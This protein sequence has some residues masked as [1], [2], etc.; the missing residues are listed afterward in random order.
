[1]KEAAF[2]RLSAQTELV[3]V[4]TAF[5]EKA[6]LAS[7]STE[8]EALS[9]TLAG[10][11]IFS[12]LSKAVSGQVLEILYSKASYYSQVT[13]RFTSQRIDWKAF[14]LTARVS[15]DE[16]ASLEDLG[17]LIA[18]RSV[19]RLSIR[20]EKTGGV[21]LTLIKEKSYPAPAAGSPVRGR[22]LA[23]F[24]VRVPYGEELKLFSERVSA[25]Y[26]MERVPTA[27]R[28][29]GRMADLAIEG[30]YRAV[31][32]IGPAGQMGGGIVWHGSGT[33]NVECFGPYLFDQDQDSP[34]AATLL[35]ACLGAIGRTPAVCLINRFPGQHVPASYFEPLG[36]V[37]FFSGK[38][39]PYS[40]QAFFRQIQEDPGT[41][42]WIHP[43]LEPFLRGEF[44]RLVLPREIHLVRDRGERRNPSSV[45]SAE[46]D[47]L[48]GQVTLRPI[49]SGSDVEENVSGHLELLRREGWPNIFFEMDLAQ[50]WQADFTPALL[51][52]GFIPR[53]ILPYGGE[54][55]VVL[56]Q[57]EEAS[58]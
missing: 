21:S 11:E 34:M 15:P 38:G 12:Y 19:D 1:M 39:V 9:M 47:K 48:Q 33:K 31:L 36:T 10:E 30:E 41:S 52:K 50:P 57:A 5:I 14:N 28:F 32:A 45:L 35:D 7:G 18:S 56:F 25:Y 6:S 13:F 29:P 4:V 43:E 46:F 17:L 23:E 40:V 44:R 58:A 37:T 42:A 24:S 20:Q 51:K 54:G 22:P 26:P 53:L 2:L 16:E 3:P 49:L 8:T 55:D 27:L